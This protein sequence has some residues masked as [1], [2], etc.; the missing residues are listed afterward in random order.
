MKGSGL[1][2]CRVE[3]GRAPGCGP[4]GHGRN[5]VVVGCEIAD[6]TWAL[7]DWSPEE[8]SQG[9]PPDFQ[10]GDGV[11]PPGWGGMGD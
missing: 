5:K 9:W 6:R 3:D 10:F 2:G 8:R 11:H 7:T 4:R 1:P